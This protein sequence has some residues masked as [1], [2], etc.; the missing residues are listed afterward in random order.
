MKRATINELAA[1]IREYSGLDWDCM[2]DIEPAVYGDTACIARRGDYIYKI[3][4]DSLRVLHSELKGEC[5][6]CEVEIY[7]IIHGEVMQIGIQGKSLQA[8]VGEITGV[9]TMFS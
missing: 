1:A 4:G 5:H 8:L 7:H 9:I 2:K 6:I 3:C